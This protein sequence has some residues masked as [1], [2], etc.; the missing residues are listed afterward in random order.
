R[1]ATMKITYA[2]HTL[3]TD[4]MLAPKDAYDG[5][6]GLA[7]NPT[8]GLPL[9]VEEILADVEAVLVS[10]D[11]PDHLDPAAVE[12]LP[13]A[14]PLFCQP[15]E[16]EKMG[17]NGFGKVTVIEDSMKWE[18]ITLTR[19]GGAHGRGEIGRRM[20]PVSGFVLQ[21]PSEPTLYWVGDSIWCEPV[22]SAI[23]QH[24]PDIIVTHSGGATLPGF[25]PIIMDARETLRVARSAP[26]AVVVAVHLEAL[27]HCPVTR[28]E[29]R[30][31]AEEAGIP[32]SRLLIP[33]DGEI[34]RLPRP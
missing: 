3:L 22:E 32:S 21:A 19:T 31:S 9:A 6:A 10:H 17:A 15:G 8:V 13:K 29:L 5:F 23:A 2:G 4:P 26:D 34:M 1:N 28:R 11:H 16:V 30:R 33:A 27:D 24:R 25:D 12:L 18:A 20:G 14:L 7:R